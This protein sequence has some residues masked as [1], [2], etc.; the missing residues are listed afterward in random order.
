[1]ISALR[2]VSNFDPVAEL[3][4]RRR[5]TYPEGAVD[6]LVA[7]LRID[8]SS[9]V[10]DLGAGTGKLTRA[11]VPRAAH[12]IAVDPG[13]EMLAQLRRVVPQAEA[14][15]GA[16]ESIP[17]GDD[18]VDA[19]VCGQ[20]FHW[21]RVDEARVEIRRVLR[22][23]RGLGLIWN[24][25]DQDDELQRE[26]TKLLAPLV[27]QD[28]ATHSG[29]RVFVSDTFPD[30]EKFEVRFERELDADGLAEGLASTS[31]VATAS[32]HERTKL[33]GEFRNLVAARGGRVAFRYVT[34]AYVTYA[35]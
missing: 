20:S 9:T 6:W 1:M 4:E 27:P 14:V 22:P 31:F 28:H 8:T 32:E 21:F 30:V 17:L 19:V 5:P 24:S 23:G 29:V 33:L 12:V 11:L 7:R 25:R 26:I 15:V 13:T 34:Q 2:V 3:Y 16:A 18:S 35:V 10:L